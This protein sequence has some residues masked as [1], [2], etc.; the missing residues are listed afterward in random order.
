MRL[1]NEGWLRLRSEGWLRLR[2]WSKGRLRRINRHR[3]LDRLGSLDWL[4]RWFVRLIR[5]VLHRLRVLLLRHLRR[6]ELL[7]R[8]EGRIHLLLL[9]MLL[10]LLLGIEVVLHWLKFGF[11]R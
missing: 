5:L 11:G 8:R 2:L 9:L 3:G 4:N 6:L 1:R 10:L 7:R